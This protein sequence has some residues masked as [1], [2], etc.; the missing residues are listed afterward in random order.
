MMMKSIC[1]AIL[2]EKRDSSIVFYS[3]HGEYDMGICP[4]G[5]RGRIDAAV[6]IW[7][8]DFTSGPRAYCT[9]G[10]EIKT[11]VSNLMEDRKLDGKYLDAGLFDYLFLVA[12]S[13]EIALKACVKYSQNDAIGVASLGSGRVLKIPAKQPVTREARAFF[14]KH[15]EERAKVDDTSRYYTHCCQDRVFAVL[16]MLHEKQVLPAIRI[17]SP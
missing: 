6:I 11:S 5:E 14:M 17:I 3:V 12:V 1:S 9:L 8:P 10:L 7:H 16:D 15:L 13:D 2:P 4:G